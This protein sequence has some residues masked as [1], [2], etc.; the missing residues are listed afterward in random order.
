MHTHLMRRLI[1]LLPF[2][3]LTAFT[4]L[5]TGAQAAVTAPE[6]C[7]VGQSAPF[8]PVVHKED[9]WAKNSSYKFP[10][11]GW[12]AYHAKRRTPVRSTV[13]WKR[14]SNGSGRKAYYPAPNMP[15]CRTGRRGIEDRSSFKALTYTGTL[16]ALDGVTRSF[17]LK[18]SFDRFVATLDYRTRSPIKR[19]PS[20]YGWYI[21]DKWAGH[22]A[23]K[24]FEI[25]GKA[26][27][28]S[29]VPVTDPVTGA[30]VRYVWVRDP[31]QMMIAINP[32]LG[33]PN[34]N[35]RPYNLA[36]L[37]IR[38]FIPIEAIPGGLRYLANR[39]DFGCGADGGLP[40]LLPPQPTMAFNI[41]SGTA[42]NYMQN[43]YF[44]EGAV[45]GEALLPG[46]KKI[47]NNMPYSNYNF[48]PQLGN[49]MYLANNTTGVASGGMVRALIRGG[50]DQFSL[51]D[52]MTYCDP[53]Y[54]LKNM[55]IFSRGNRVSKAIYFP[56]RS[57]D[58]RNKPGVRW[59]YGEVT[60]DPA[61]LSPEGQI[62]ATQ[63]DSMKIFGWL[64]IYCDR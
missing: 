45:Q 36:G 27:K 62:A 47:Y 63:A 32:A 2:A 16:Y 64:P 42:D 29:P 15:S 35:S 24:M 57:Y 31:T 30:I 38:A 25:Q 20:R 11:Y 9:V 39:Y 61:T 4:L 21:N 46:E 53:N 34:G 59:V 3:V 44:G 41:K 6:T 55:R 10:F 43:Q 23:E 17:V 52:E 33:S 54:T 13:L 7:A 12:S 49:T 14:I 37:K 40:P 56:Q 26:C 48:D 51:I 22:D 5:T 8:Q 1:K 60:P 58:P 50:I 18:D 19:L 28:L